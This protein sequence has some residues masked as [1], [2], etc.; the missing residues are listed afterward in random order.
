MRIS[1][2]ASLYLI[3]ILLLPAT[4]KNTFTAA[5]ATQT[6]A[7]RKEIRKDSEVFKKWM[8]SREPEVMQHVYPDARLAAEPPS[9]SDKY[10][11]LVVEK[12]RKNASHMKDDNG[13]L[14]SIYPW[15]FN[16]T[17]AGQPTL[18]RKTKDLLLKIYTMMDGDIPGLFAFLGKHGLDSYELNQ[19]EKATPVKEIRS[20][21]TTI[22]EMLV[23][24]GEYS[25]E[26][27]RATAVANRLAEFCFGADTWPA[28]EKYLKSENT[29]P[30]AR[31]AYSVVWYYLSGTGW[32]HW[33][34]D[35]ISNLKNEFNAGAKIVYIAGGNDVYQLIK[36]GIYNIEVI[37][38]L[39]PTQPRFYSEGWDFLFKK[40]GIGDEIV[41]NF[42]N[43]PK[44]FPLTHPH[45]LMRRAHYEE[46][47]PFTALLNT[48]KKE[49][50]MS[51]KTGWEIYDRDKD[52]RLGSL[53]ISRRF[54]NQDDFVRGK[55][56]A[57][58]M[59][60]NELFFV[61]TPDTQKSWG[62][63]PDKFSP[64]F[65]MYVKQLRKPVTREMVLNI[66]KGEQS[67]LKFLSLGS[68]V[69]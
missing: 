40:D 49:Q 34:R 33:H 45:L 22:L 30:L 43:E 58:V 52:S 12:Y 63:N 50:I 9:A 56:R 39:L 29:R 65:K 19:K 35:A 26:R 27:K 13:L 36:A 42:D 4:A 55:G 47:E 66:R 21:Y 20:K 2:R 7:S 32:K 53:L 54:C 23:A 16:D 5:L 17:T 10:P 18:D 14:R 25:L 61:A 6:E 41:L 28:F 69:N 1:G 44:S 8:A 60:F 51:S 64:D 24:A 67:Q 15:D 68:E 62:I 11:R 48:G 31:F 37:D 57:L 59:S 38:P 46:G 3:V